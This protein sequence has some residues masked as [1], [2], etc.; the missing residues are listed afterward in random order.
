MVVALSLLAG[1]VM[2]LRSPDSATEAI[3]SVLPDAFARSSVFMLSVWESALAFGMLLL[4]GLRTGLALATF[5]TIGVL[6]AGLVV[7]RRRGLADNCGC[8]GDLD[9]GPVGENLRNAVLLTLTAVVFGT[10]ATHPA[11]PLSAL[12]VSAAHSSSRY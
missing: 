3:G 11:S 8:F 1:A 9:I 4:P 6:A 2:K 7:A 10:S 5:V 12:E